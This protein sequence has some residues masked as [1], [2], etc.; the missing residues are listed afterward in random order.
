MR[1]SAEY[2]ARLLLEELG[3]ARL[4]ELRQ[5]GV[6]PATVARMVRAG[7]VQQ[8]A[9]GMYQLTDAEGHLHHDMAKASK[10]VPDGVVCLVS[11]LCFH[12]LTREIPTNTFMAIG[13]K[14][15]APANGGVL[16]VTERYPARLLSHGVEV[17]AIE[18]VPVKIFSAP[19]AV[20]DC[21]RVPGLVEPWIASEG[22][23]NALN[24]GVAT[25]DELAALA[26]ARGCHEQIRPHLEDAA[27]G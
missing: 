27:N 18:N 10:R 23:H 4:D 14:A 25:L 20:V 8:V 22:L 15:R 6:A 9:R 11:A 21:F 17:H 5:G 19:C 3:I 7:E 13:P 1:Q 2:A 16:F 12:V 24:H 26:H